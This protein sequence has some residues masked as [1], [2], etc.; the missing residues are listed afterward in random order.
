[1]MTMTMKTTT[2]TTMIM[3]IVIMMLLVVLVI[4]AAKELG[5]AFLAWAWA[6]H[7]NI[8]SW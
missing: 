4:A 5:E 7:H 1:M 3:M 8:L 6:R 2:R